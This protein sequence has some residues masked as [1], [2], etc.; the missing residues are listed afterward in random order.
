MMV[1]INFYRAKLDRMTHEEVHKEAFRLGKLLE[2]RQLPKSEKDW[3]KAVFT[4]GHAIVENP[5]EKEAYRIAR[6]CVD[7]L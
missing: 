4:Y 7:F 1:V 6:W 2:Q 5:A 3:A